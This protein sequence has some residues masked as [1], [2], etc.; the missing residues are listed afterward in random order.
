MDY[1]LIWI[2]TLFITS[3][4]SLLDGNMTAVLMFDDYR[5]ITIV[6]LTFCAFFFYTKALK[7]FRTIKYKVELVNSTLMFSAILMI[8]GCF[9]PYTDNGGNFL[10]DLHVICSMT[11]TLLLLLHLFILNRKLALIELDIYLKTHWIIDYGIQMLVLL[12]IVFTRVNGYI[13]IVYTTILCLYMYLVE[14]EF[15]LQKKNL[16]KF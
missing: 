1:F 7:L 2:L 3:R 16:K 6:F 10:S 14:R 8:I 12:I 15:Y 9:A 13:E 5:Y 11:S 4:D